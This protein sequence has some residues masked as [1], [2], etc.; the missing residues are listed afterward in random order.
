MLFEDLIGRNFRQSGLLDISHRPFFKR[1]IETS[2][3]YTNHF[4]CEN[5]KRIDEEIILYDSFMKLNLSYLIKK[6]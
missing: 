6:S 3:L 2:T 5:Q 4:F 1:N